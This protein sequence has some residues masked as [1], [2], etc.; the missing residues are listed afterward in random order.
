[1]G[2]GEVASSGNV[3][4]EVLK[5]LQGGAVGG[6]GATEDCASGGAVSSDWQAVVVISTT[7]SLREGEEEEEDGAAASRAQRNES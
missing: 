5:G 3:G 7:S 2:C 1:M 6:K 4:R